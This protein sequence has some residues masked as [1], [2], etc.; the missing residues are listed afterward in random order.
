MQ[1]SAGSTLYLPPG[2]YRI[3]RTVRLTGPLIG[4]SVIGHGRDTTLVWDGEAGG[5]LFADDGV[6]YSRYIG[7]QFDGRGKAAVGFH[8]DSHKRFETEVRHI[9]LAFRN[10]TDAAV[11]AEPATAMR[12]RKPSST[13]AC[14]KTAA[15]AS[16]S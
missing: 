3:T 2:N 6:A 13:T 1:S 10:F 14:S 12:W 5:K 7:I 9:H 11:L 8:H 4:V 15:V 16:R